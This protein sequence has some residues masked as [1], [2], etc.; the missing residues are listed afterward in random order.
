MAHEKHLPSSRNG[1]LVTILRRISLGRRSNVI[2]I[3]PVEVSRA[4]LVIAER[5]ARS[6]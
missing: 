5:S 4:G 1:S 2:L 6:I 3:L